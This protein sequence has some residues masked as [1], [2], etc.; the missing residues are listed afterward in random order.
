MAGTQRKS[1]PAPVAK[2]TPPAAPV[3]PV[4]A[5]SIPDFAALASQQTVAKE[6]P[7]IGRNGQENPFTD[8]VR[9]SFEKKEAYTLPPIPQEAL[10]P[11]KVAIRRGATLAD[12]GVSIREV[13][14]ENGTIEITYMGKVRSKRDA[15]S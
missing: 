9:E 4:A 14:L 3:A 6:L 7:K 2:A 13:K 8:K 12:L 15:T 1:A 10:T 5:K 11:V